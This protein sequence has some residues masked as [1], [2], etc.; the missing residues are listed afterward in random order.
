MGADFLG[1][2]LMGFLPEGR[3]AKVHP[4]KNKLS[5]RAHYPWLRN[6]FKVCLGG[7]ISNVNVRNYW[8][9]KGSFCL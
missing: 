5:G 4:A 7:G 3:V 1:A 8:A 6:S 2:N 9:S